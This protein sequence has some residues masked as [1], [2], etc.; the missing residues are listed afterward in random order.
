MKLTPEQ[1]RAVSFDDGNLLILACAGSGKTEVVSRRIARLVARGVEKQSIA[2]FTF[3]ERAAG[4]FKNRVRSHLEEHVRHDSALG[5]MYI[6][7]IHSLCLEILRDLNPAYRIYEILDE[8]R[9][10]ALVSSKYHSAI[11]GIGLDRVQ[12]YLARKGY[13]S[14]IRTFVTTLNVVHQKSIPIDTISRAEVRDAIKRYQEIAYGSPN[15]FWDFDKIIDEL[16]DYLERTP[17]KLAEVRRRFKH[18]FVD[19]YQDVDD[20]QERLIQLLSDRG[21]Q[22]QVTVVGDDDQAIYGW[23]GAQ[24][25]NIMQFEKAYH[26]AHRIELRNNFRSRH[27]IVEIANNASSKIGNRLISKTME[28][29]RW[30]DERSMFLEHL[31]ERGDVRVHKFGSDTEEA[32][33]IADRILQLRGAPFNGKL[34]TRGLDYSDFAILLRS[35]RSAGQ[36]YA[37]A[38]RRRRIPFV[39]K[40]AGG[41][42]DNPEAELIYLIFCLLARTDA[43]VRRKNNTEKIEEA[44]VRDRV[45]EIVGTINANADTILFHDPN[46]ILNW[47]SQQRE[48]LDRRMLSK[49]KRG[50]ISRRIYPQDIYQHLLAMLKAPGDLCPWPAE[51]MYNL[52]QISRLITDFES[53]HQW[54]T[55]RNLRSLCFFLAVRGSEMDEGGNDDAGSLNA[56]QI[57]TVHAAKGLEWPAVFLPRVSSMIFPS[58]KRNQGPVTLLSPRQFDSKTL[59]S[60]DDGE[61]RLWYVALTRC[62]K[63]LHVTALEYT[64][65]KPTE[66]YN[67]IV[68]DYVERNVDARFDG[69]K[70]EPQPESDVELIPTTFTDLNYF[71]RCQYEY[72]IRSLMGFGPGVKESYGY[73]QQIHNVLAEIYRRVQLGDTVTAHD[74][75]VLVDELFHLRYTKDGE[76]YKP[77]TEL[78]EAAKKTLRRFI[79]AYPESLTNAVVSE[80][81]FEFVEKASGALISGTIDLLRSPDELERDTQRVVVVDFK[82]HRFKS[83]EDFRK[84]KEA[85]E[86]QVRLYAIAVRQALGYDPVGAV[87]HFLSPAPP[88]DEIRSKVSEKVSI[89][90]DPNFQEQ[91]LSKVQ[92]AVRDI[93]TSLGAQR[94][95]MTG[96]RSGHCRNCDYRTFCPGYLRW[97]QQDRSTPRPPPLDEQRELEMAS[98]G[99]DD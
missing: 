17:E 21:R 69:A 82:T 7:T 26:N 10:L 39:V 67:E 27:A 35:V 41:L 33:W 94:F 30:S 61:R 65:K 71:W 52:G 77:L 59:A 66:F 25:G 46:S 38:L 6:G 50:R 70:I 24:L 47:V 49:D 28:A 2:A 53:V 96:C 51:V 80:K 79:E 32:D 19:E 4:E 31:S 97:D 15:Y 13:W 89:N 45:R 43:I 64:R 37:N 18:I 3:T 1:E 98:I 8:S 62:M 5:D 88:R 34:E 48:Y 93:R 86:N 85:A 90:V 56:V 44:D 11:D 73:G 68:H 63:Y 16:I 20:K 99:E 40:G 83:E 92:S 84:S 14:A 9:Q 75:E 74:A 72:Q 29:R 60:G 12:K 78:R 87:A 57:T 76:T 95:E 58:S 54:I 55:P 36:I 81:N 23:R 42:F 91:I 22:V